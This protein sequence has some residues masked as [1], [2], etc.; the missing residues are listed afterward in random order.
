M[1]SEEIKEAIKNSSP[2]T[3]K[4]TEYKCIT[5][6]IYRRIIDRHTGKSTF[7]LQCE[8][9]DRSGHS[10]VIVDAKKVEMIT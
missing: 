9:L 10:V 1:T 2:V 8:L 3:Y 6:Y 7:I 5:A 4:G